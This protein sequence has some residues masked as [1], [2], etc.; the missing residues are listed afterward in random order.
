M[1][2]GSRLYLVRHGQ[3]LGYERFPIYGLTDVGLTDAGLLQFEHLAE[4]LRFTRIDA[5]YSSDLKRSIEGARII[6]RY[7]D[8]SHQIRP[9]LQ[10]IHFG[11]WEGLGFKDV[12]EQFPE[13][14]QSRMVDPV[15]FRAPGDGETVAELSKRVMAC[16]AEV[17]NTHDGHDFLIVGHG[18][19]NRV[20]IC[21]A[22]GLELR[23]MFRLQQDYGALN[24]IDYF[25]DSTLVRL[26]N[27]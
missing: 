4:R 25:P 5:I 12:R 13:K 18:A 23:Y 15:Q 14:V 20:I 3:V 16:L 21:D 1:E 27:G 6:G 8:V 11:D 26:M 9:E 19:V 10:E 22:L 2:K 17:L 7:H 24:I